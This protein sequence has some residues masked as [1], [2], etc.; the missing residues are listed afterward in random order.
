[1]LA[2]EVNPTVSVEEWKTYVGS[3]PEGTY[4]HLPQ[5]QAVIKE[6]LGHKPF[7]IF[8][9]NEEGKLCGVLPLFRVGSALTGSRLV[10]LPF[11]TAC[12]PIADSSDTTEALVE[13]AKGLC[14]EMR[15]QYLEIRT[16]RPLSLGLEVSEFF[17][18]YVLELSESRSVWE[19]VDRRARQ[20]VA[21]AR[22]Q[23]V[24]VR[25]DDS[26]RGLELFSHMNLRNKRGLGSPTYPIQFFKAM[27]Q[28]MNSHFRIYLAEVEG[29]VVAGAA[30]TSFKGVTDYGCAASDSRYEKHRPNDA[31]TW[32]AIEDSGNE[33]CRCFDFGKTNSD[34]VSLAQFK[35][36]WGAEKKTLYY[37]YYP[38]GRNLASSDRYGMKGIK[39]ELVTGLWKRLPLPIMRVVNP[40]AIRHLD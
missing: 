25:V 40:I 2:I 8:A 11:S 15:C 27:R 4:F 37:H 12:G 30:V 21:K 36:K 29:K 20:A 17:H 22:K 13:K 39:Y 14:D 35:K 23:G 31:V 32:Q 1:M 28:H 9:R 3:H 26:E 6:S 18:T 16:M 5:W 34:N 19:G 10:S 38:K 24:V 33:G 7:Y